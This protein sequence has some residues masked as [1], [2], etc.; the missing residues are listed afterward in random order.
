[1][2]HTHAALP[3]P[4]ERLPRLGLVVGGAG[5]VVSAI[6]AIAAPGAL[7]PAYLVAFL[8]WVGI[9]LGCLSA[10]ML[11]YLV[12]GAWGFV[13]R[14]PLESAVMT[15]PLMGV[16]FLLLLP[17]LHVLYPWSVPEVVKHDPALQHKS[18]YLNVPFFVIRAIIYFVLWSGLA[19]ALR[20]GSSVQARTEDPRPTWR[21][22]AL[23]GPG[24]ALTFLAVT[25]AM[26]DWGM[27]LEPHWFSTIYGAMLLVG[28]G[29]SALSA[30][31]IVSSALARVEPLTELAKPEPFNELGN[32]MLAFVMLWAYM[33]FSQYLIIWSGNLT[34][35]IPWYLRR[36]EHGWRWLAA[37]LMIFHFFVPFF[38][39][40]FRSN[41]RQPQYLWRVAAFLLLMQWLN[42]IWLVIPA[43]PKAGWLWPIF[44]VGATAGIGGLWI[45]LFAWLMAQRPLLPRNDPLLADVLLHHGEH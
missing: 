40:L 36:S 12:G 4:W 17:G 25:F 8:F 18:V 38:L 11:H 22:Q 21:L 41:K 24:L 7:F 34:E 29:L 9:S 33:S 14:R 23:S 26:I 32:L 27:S 13:I 42:D 28:G 10:L 15:L 45:A 37:L 2:N 20:W 5:L 16:L 19:S 44:L 39:L 35:E 6:G 43:F 3:T 30:M 1:M 31:V